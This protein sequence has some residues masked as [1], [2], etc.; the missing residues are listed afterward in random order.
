MIRVFEAFSGVGAQHM[1]LRNLNLNYEIVATSEIDINAILAYYNVH[2]NNGEQKE[3]TNLELAKKHIIFLGVADD[4]KL[5][6]MSD[7]AVLELYNA[8][9]KSKNLGDITKI[10]HKKG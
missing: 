6:K 1:A 3:K 4:K 10:E 5:A 8:C 2:E 7:E 9:I